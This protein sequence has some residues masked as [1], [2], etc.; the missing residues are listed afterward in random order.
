MKK[1]IDLAK[2]VG[3]YKKDHKEEVRNTA[4]ED[5]VIG[6]YRRFAEE[7]GM[8]PDSAEEICKLL[9]KESVDVQEALR[10]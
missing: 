2:E 3:R 1:R 7:N 4:V 6:R 9:M 8:N 10:R 5:K